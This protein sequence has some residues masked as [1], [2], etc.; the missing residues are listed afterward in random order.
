MNLILLQLHDNI[1]EVL[2]SEIGTLCKL[3][4]LNLSSNR[5][6]KLPLKLYNLGELR[7][8]DVCNNSLEEVDAAVGDLVMLEN[9]VLK[10]IIKMFLR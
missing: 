3:R 1:I 2:P 5:L 7:S 4:S 6:H 8:F 9:L 10:F